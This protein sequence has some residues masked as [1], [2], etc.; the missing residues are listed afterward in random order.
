[1]SCIESKG[2]G[3]VIGMVALLSHYTPYMNMVCSVQPFALCQSQY[4]MLVLLPATAY[5]ALNL[6][7]IL[8]VLDPSCQLGTGLITS[9]EVV[10]ETTGAICDGPTQQITHKVLC[11]NIR[12]LFGFPMRL[13]LISKIRSPCIARV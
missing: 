13:I 4:I 5:Q 10:G 3:A 7:I 11:K 9:K 12:N 2:A 8:Q 6:V 1:M